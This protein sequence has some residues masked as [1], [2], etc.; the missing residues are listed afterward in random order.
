MFGNRNY[1]HSFK[2]LGTFNSNIIEGWKYWENSLI[3]LP[4]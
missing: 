4:K 3:V 2:F 1:N